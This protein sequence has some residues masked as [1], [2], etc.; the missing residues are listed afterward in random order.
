M[1]FDRL[2]EADLPD[3]L[4]LSTQAGWNQTEADWRRILDVAP[5][6]CLA[7]RIGDRLVAT[8][9]VVPYG[10]PAGWVG[11]VIVDRAER[12]RGLGGRLL[13]RTVELSRELGIE[14]LGLDATDL[15]RP[16]YLKLGFA[17][18]APIDRWQGTLR[19]L[20]GSA[21]SR[22]PIREILALDRSVAGLDRGPLLEH[23]AGEKGMVCLTAGDLRGYAFLRPGRE[24]FHLGPVVALDETAA[25]GLLDAAADRLAGRSVLVDAPRTPD[26]DRLMGSRGLTVHRRLTRM[27]LSP[28]RRVLL[29]KELLAATAFEWG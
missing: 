27:T 6:G 8:A 7:G 18:V 9:T 3:A 1:R 13:E 22:L 20:G 16:V 2:T 19:S 11:M 29:G 17:D 24:H 26:T 5:G 15:G 28:P 21:D 10:T 4:R 25:A 14:A 12:G 23:L